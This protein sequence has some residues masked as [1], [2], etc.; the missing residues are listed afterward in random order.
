MGLVNG[1]IAVIIFF[2]IL[3]SIQ[4]T[5][6][7]RFFSLNAV[8][9]K[10]SDS[11]SEKNT[12]A[13]KAR[14]A[15][16]ELALATSQL[17]VERYRAAIQ[18]APDVLLSIDR[19]GKIFIANEAPTGNN[20]DN[21]IGKNLFELI[22]S[23]TH[24]EKLRHALEYVFR[25]GETASYEHI[26]GEGYWHATRVS[27]IYKDGVIISATVIGRNISENK[28][29]ETERARLFDAEREQRE[30]AEALRDAGIAFSSTLDLNTILKTLLDQIAR[31]VSYDAGNVMVVEGNVARIA[32]ARGYEHFGDNAAEDI[33]GLVFDID[34]TFNL[35]T[36][37]E[38]QQP[39]II[40][41]TEKDTNWIHVRPKT[42]I[43]SWA[44]APIIVQGEVVAFFSLDKADS[45]FYQMSDAE[46][47]SAFAGQAAIAIKNARLFEQTRSALSRT[48][49]LQNVSQ[50]LIDQ[51]TLT[52]VLQSVVE[53]I[54]KSLPAHTVVLS[55]PNIEAQD[56]AYFVKGGPGAKEIDAISFAHLKD[57]LTHW[58][59]KDQ[60]P[61]K[62]QKRISALLPGGTPS[63]D[64]SRIIEVPLRYQNNILG[65]LIAI[66]KHGHPSYT[67]SDIEL[68]EAMANQAAIAIQN[69]YWH[70]ESQKQAQ[71]V[72]QI[73]NSVSLGILLLDKK[74]HIQMANPPAKEFLP[75]LQSIDPETNALKALGNLPLSHIL[76][77][78]EENAWHEISSSGEAYRLFTVSAHSVA[79]EQWVI[80]LNDITEAR[81]QQHRTQQQ[82]R[83]AAIGQMA[84]GFAHDF[85]NIL[86]SMIG[87]A[88]LLSRRP[89]LEAAPKQQLFHI[90]S[91]GKRAAELIT[92]LLDFSRQTANP[93][94]STS[95]ES[96]LTDI[97]RYLHNIL[98]QR[99][100]VSL[101]IENNV[102][103]SEISLDVPRVQQVFFN[104]AHNAQDAMPDGGELQLHAF[105]L[106]LYP[107]EPAPYPTMPA[108]TWI[109]ISIADTGTGIPKDILPHVFEPFF[110]TK[111]VGAGTGMGLSQAYGIMKQH[112]GYITVSSENNN[113]T[114]VNLYFPENTS[115]QK[116]RSEGNHGKLVLLVDDELA[117]LTKGKALLE[118]SG[119]S[120]ITAQ[121]GYKA[122]AEFDSHEHNLTAVLMDI[123]MARLGGNSLAKTLKERNSSIPLIGLVSKTL[124]PTGTATMSDS[125]SHWLSKPLD[126]ASVVALMRELS[127]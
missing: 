21:I 8:N 93:T 124:S 31:V 29:L 119:Y 98:P 71:L 107:D 33:K 44:G 115:R 102:H 73:L 68:M 113:G 16:L 104:L 6:F 118:Q 103:T 34:N 91:Q 67:N 60:S 116:S 89:N 55:T 97:T 75:M 53:S 111:D 28:T 30:L 45:D 7:L 86:T 70:E 101:T 54:A 63:Q 13:L 84:S 65:T 96:F 25:T 82:E 22:T 99:I 62:L 51:K 50:Q 42:K 47:L 43:R 76:E 112:R 81:Q 120:V 127:S 69:V 39:L 110:T 78:T 92:Q 105:Q 77:I 72:E 23:D 88:D 10:K 123:S 94:T 48:E 32:Q 3:L 66:N 114:I 35:R 19:H 56:V 12:T 95:V 106:E 40:P 2:I 20:A 58:L 59:K 100:D 117:L 80:V 5:S 125:F 1:W 17:T 79:N 9:L 49:S 15:E 85:N 83:L 27:P 4:N 41:N 64:T 24:R 90:V 57:N 108:G 18:N 26:D 87:F 14:I 11:P 121:D 61:S 52:S 74:H 36:M 46:R 109:A 37:V 38:T 126:E 122:L